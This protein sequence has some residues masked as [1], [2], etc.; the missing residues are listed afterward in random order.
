M[1]LFLSQLKKNHSRLVDDSPRSRPR[2]WCHALAL[3]I[4]EPLSRLVTQTPIKNNLQAGSLLAKAQAART[5]K[6]RVC[7]H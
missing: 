5:P 1:G 7:S 4:P 2:S 3:A 6:L